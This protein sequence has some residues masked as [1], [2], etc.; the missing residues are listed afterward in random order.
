MEHAVTRS[1]QTASEATPGSLALNG[2]PRDSECRIQG[3]SPGASVL[4]ELGFH[5]FLLGVTWK[6]SSTQIKIGWPR[7]KV[8][9]R[10]AL[11]N[12]SWGPGDWGWLVLRRTEWPQVWR[13]IY[14][15]VGT[16]PRHCVF[17]DWAHC[18]P[19]RLGQNQGGDWDK[20]MQLCEMKGKWV[21]KGERRKCRQNQTGEGETPRHSRH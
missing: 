14:R 21:F 16:P 4:T 8:Q 13:G 7:L 19:A 15:K 10:E 9:E 6:W 18:L 11:T 5:L 12:N 1:G 17:T 2:D 20:V 3:G